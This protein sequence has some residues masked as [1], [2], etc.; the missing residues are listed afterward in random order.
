MGDPRCGGF[1]IIRPSARAKSSS[2]CWAFV[3]GHF[4]L[5]LTPDQ[6]SAFGDTVA[7][8][9]SGLFVGGTDGS[10]SGVLGLFANGPRHDLPNGTSLHSQ[11]TGN[12]GIDFHIDLGNP[13]RDIAGI[14]HHV[15]WDIFKRSKCLDAPFATNGQGSPQ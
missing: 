15:G 11:Q 13:Y 4:N 9:I 12:N 6:I 5:V 7:G 10:A 8:E 14:V 3:G 2:E 1:L